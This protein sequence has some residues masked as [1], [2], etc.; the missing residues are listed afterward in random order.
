ME[1]VG[2]SFASELGSD[3]FVSFAKKTVSD[4]P[5]VEFVEADSEYGFNYPYFIYIPDEIRSGEPPILVEPNNTGTSTDDFEE[6]IE[7]AELQLREG[8]GTRQISD[9]LDIPLIV[10]VF[11][12]PRSEPVDWEHYTHALDVETLEI[13]SGKLERID[14]QLLSMV[15]H[16]KENLLSDRPV[17]FSDKIILNGFSASGNFVDRFAVLHPES[18]LSVTAGGLNGMALLPKAEMDGHELPYHVGISDIESLIG[19]SFD[20]D[21]LDR[22]NQYLYMGSEDDNDTIG[23]GDAWTEDG[24]EETALEVYGEDI[25]GERF[26][27]CQEAY[28]EV[29]IEAQFKI[30]EGVGHSPREARDDIVEF[31]RRSIEGDDVSEF[32][33][34]LGTHPEFEINKEK[35]D[36][37]ETL[38]LDASKSK[39]NPGEIIKYTWDF[40]DG[41]TAVGKTTQHTY[42]EPG[43]YEITLKAI[44][45]IGATDTISKN[46]EV[47]TS[48]EDINADFKIDPENPMEGEQIE[49]N[50]DD[51]KS[52]EEINAYTWDFG[53]GETAVGK[54]TQHTYNEAGEYQIKL[55]IHTEKG[56]QATKTKQ[57]EIQE[58]T[59]EE[60][61]GLK[62]IS[63]L[64]GLAGSAYLLNKQKQKQQEK[65]PD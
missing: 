30:Y 7:G 18:V 50:A 13:S 16:S 53:D 33:E 49:L 32:G 63:A 4:I 20:P 62:T 19:K 64:S 26:P 57:I 21:E 41:E 40:G 29:G 25:I 10:P 5:G 27:K 61:P 22:V 58:T 35:L 3:S 36:T 43:T 52:P 45:E 60:T 46:I 39:T 48:E 42:T 47:E 51:S 8:T 37:G 14:L 59:T 28:E 11:P 2:K 34:K 15:E 65:D 31:H 44:T 38:E 24:L 17:S 12:R 6:H 23:Y 56:R 55:E 9:E 1:T 54:T